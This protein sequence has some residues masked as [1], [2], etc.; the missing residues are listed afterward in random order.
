MINLS[1]LIIGMSLL[2]GTAA[3]SDDAYIDVGYALH[4]TRLD[5][6]EVNLDKSIFEIETG[7][8]FGKAKV[9]FR[10]NSGI[11]THEIGGG[12]NLIGVRYNYSM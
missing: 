8:E 1:D 5:S 3:M 6:P 4:S 12:F 9:F 11:Q 10:H 7:V 2:F